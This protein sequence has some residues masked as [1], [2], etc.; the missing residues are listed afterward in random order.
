MKYCC[1][2]PVVGHA[3]QSLMKSKVVH[4]RRFILLFRGTRDGGYAEFMRADEHFTYRIPPGFSDAEAAPLLCAGAIGYRSLRLAGLVNGQC[5]G[6]SGFG[7]SA[8]LVL[9]MARHLYPGSPIKVYAR[10]PEE[11]IFDRELGTTR[12]GD[13]TKHPPMKAH[14]IIDTTADWSMVTGALL[15]LRTGGR[16]VINAIRKESKNQE[17]LGKS[18]TKNHLWMEKEIKSVAN[19]TRRNV[20]EFLTLTAEV[21]IKPATETYAFGQA[22]KAILDLKQKQVKGA[23]VI[24]IPNKEFTD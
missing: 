14:A 20:E 3:T 22:N 11:Q 9:K 10:S 21:P 4:L 7:A 16:L 1:G 19:I 6:F 2:L 12:A 5:L 23:K 13:I 18:G 8:P 24:V 15:Q 17:A